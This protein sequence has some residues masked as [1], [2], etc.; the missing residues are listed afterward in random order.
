MERTCSS[1]LRRGVDSVEWTNT[2][3]RFFRCSSPPDNPVYPRRV[4]P[5]D[6]TFSLHHTDTHKSSIYLSLYRLIINNNRFRKTCPLRISEFD[7]CLRILNHV[8][9][10]LVYKDKHVQRIRNKSVHRIPSNHPVVFT[11]VFNMTQYHIENRPFLSEEDFNV[12]Q[13]IV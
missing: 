12:H 9:P 10:L 1:E 3:N 7:S 2:Y 8:T 11:V 6:V 13:N 4:D 5:S